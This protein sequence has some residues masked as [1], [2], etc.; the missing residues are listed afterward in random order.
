[1]PRKLTGPGASLNKKF[2]SVKFLKPTNV[3]I[4]SVSPRVREP[5]VLFRDSVPRSSEERLTEVSVR[6]LVSELGIQLP[7]SGRLLVLV[8]KVTT[9]VLRSTRRSIVLVLVQSEV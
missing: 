2:Q 6:L 8:N 5:K 9:L 7:S 4:P 3:L 1:M